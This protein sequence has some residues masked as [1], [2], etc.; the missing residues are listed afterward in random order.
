MKNPKGSRN[1]YNGYSKYRLTCQPDIRHISEKRNPTPKTPDHGMH[2]NMP[3]TLHIMETTQG[4]INYIKGSF[5][6]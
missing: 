3:I 4:K 2:P 5:V 6:H 1:H